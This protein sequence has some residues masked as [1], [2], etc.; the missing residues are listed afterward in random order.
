MEKWLATDDV[1]QWL[2][3]MFDDQEFLEIYKWLDSEVRD[4]PATLSPE[5]QLA[6]ALQDAFYRQCQRYQLDGK[7]WMRE[8]LNED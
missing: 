6:S 3:I 4:N 2:E 5:W 8:D 1:K 7:R